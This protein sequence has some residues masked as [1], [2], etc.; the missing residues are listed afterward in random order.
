[1]LKEKG[2][3]GFLE[4]LRSRAILLNS[5]N[6]VRSL[7][8]VRFRSGQL[9]LV[10]PPERVRKAFEAVLETIA[11]GGVTIVQKIAR[12][13]PEAFEGIDLPEEFKK[14]IKKPEERT[15]EIQRV[16][17]ELV[18]AMQEDLGKTL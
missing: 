5:T 6:F 17:L 7:S 16:L 11:S 8:E 3:E 13:F 18:T 1:M 14:E 2:T 15:E 4:W 12:R 9:K 10:N